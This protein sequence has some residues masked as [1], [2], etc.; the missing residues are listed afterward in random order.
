MLYIY[1]FLIATFS[2]ASFEAN[3]ADGFKLQRLHGKIKLD[4][5]S[6][7]AAW[8]KIQPLPLTMFTPTFKSPPTEKT[9]IRIT[10]D[11]NY[12]YA[13]GRLYDSDP[14]GVQ[15]YSLVRDLD[16]GGDFFNILLDTFND[17]ES[18][19]AFVTTPSGN[20]L[21]AEIINDAE[22]SDFFNQ[23]WNNFWDCAVVQNHEGW[24]VEM[25]IPFSSLRFQDKDGEVTF[26]LITHRRIGRKNERLTFPEIQP[27]WTTAQWKASQ[28]QDVV[29]TG[30]YRRK[31]VYI[32]PYTLGGLSRTRSQV[33]APF[34]NNS[35]RELGIDLKYGL[36]NNLSVDLTVNT[37]FAQVEAD[38]QQINLTRFSLFFPEKRQFFQERSGIFSFKTGENSR[39]FHSRR[40]GLTGDGE[41]V[42]LLGGVRF[43]GRIN[44]W[45]V[46]FLNMQTGQRKAS[47]S[48]NFGVLRLRRRIFNDKSFV[49]GMAT[50]RIDEDGDYNYTYGLDGNFQLLD[51]DY[52]VVK[53]AH[54]LEDLAD[55]QSHK[56]L[57]NSS[58]FSV[59]YE[60]R[61][62]KGLGFSSELRRSGKNFN[63]GIGFTLR[64]D[65][66]LFK[67]SIAFGKFMNEASA[68]RRHTVAFES[69]IFL[70]N[71]DRSVESALHA[72]SWR[73]E[74]KSGTSA[75]LEVEWRRED[76]LLPFELSNQANVPVG[77]YDFF[78]TEAKLTMTDGRQLRT[79]GSINGGSF[80]DGTRFGFMLSPTWIQSRHLEVGAEVE[81]NRIRFSSRRQSFNSMLTRLRLQAAV[82]NRFSGNALLQYSNIAES[83]GINARLRYNFSEGHDLYFVYNEFFAEE[84]NRFTADLSQQDSRTF[85]LKYARTFVH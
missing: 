55:E 45:D 71:T 47:P 67:N 60:R 13:S 51:S 14:E 81:V 16:R 8:E 85:L 53:G 54:T 9:E 44:E 29:L 42:R 78:T 10:Y 59:F 5:L 82:N 83:I 48:E 25:R 46:G 22:G 58:F 34:S 66:Q 2:F 69:D 31:P 36:T 65:F 52:L 68:F 11:D 4:G 39:L 17:N 24:F 77:T 74:F 18:L 15:A 84:K 73:P 19:L 7:E 56:D 23:N 57:A 30:V 79:N 62:E 3:A 61:N 38:N 37:D 41:A 64:R 35:T 32:S 6:N 43:V 80:Y 75:E 40:I 28:A 26:G 1:L 27:K 70:R 21:D 50:S 20:R 76:L 72:F 63:P 33:N 49:G 12:L